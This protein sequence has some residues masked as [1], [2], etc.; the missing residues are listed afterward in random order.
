SGRTGIAQDVPEQR[1]QRRH[2]QRFFAADLQDGSLRLD[3]W[4]CLVLS[5]NEYARRNRRRRTI[6]YERSGPF[7]AVHHS[8][9]CSAGAIDHCAFSLRTP[10]EPERDQPRVAIKDLHKSFGEQKV[11][12]GIN[13]S[14]AKGEILAVLGRSGTGKSVLLKLLIGLEKPDAGSVCIEG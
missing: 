3:H 4:C 10:M 5:G 9:G 14:V 2:F 11:L 1:P 6:R 12:N 8:C 7:L 13:L